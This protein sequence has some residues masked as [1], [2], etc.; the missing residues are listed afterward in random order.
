MGLP[1]LRVFLGAHWA[2]SV[3]A[4]RLAGVGP[5]RKRI[6]H[7]LLTGTAFLHSVM[8]RRSADV[9]DVEYCGW[10]SPLLLAI[11][12]TFLTRSGIISRYTPFAQ[13][14][15][16]DWFAWFLAITLIVFLFFFFKN[17]IAPASEHK[18]Q[19]LVSPNP[20][21]VQQSCFCFFASRCSGYLVPED[22]ELVQGN[23]VT[24]GAPF[25]QSR[26]H[27]CSLAAPDPYRRGPAAGV[28][29]NFAGSL[30]RNF[31]GRLS[32]RC[33]CYLFDGH[34]AEWGSAFGLKPWKDISYFYC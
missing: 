21:P 22:S 2:Y 13:S 16:G 33:G 20:V 3:F 27:P 23:K 15:I 34:A 4:G 10:S 26:R 30:K 9:E 1:H 14:S 8:M 7:A 25:L 32:G 18:A 31:I 11:L 17:Q 12:G 6:A 19:S 28:A 29:Q 5:G 24:V